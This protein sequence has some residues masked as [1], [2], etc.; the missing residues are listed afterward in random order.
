M[1]DH[2]HD[3]DVE[4][5]LP[6]G[7]DQDFILPAVIR[8]IFP[9]DLLADELAELRAAAVRTIVRVPLI[10]GLFGGFQ[11]VFGGREVRLA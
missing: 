11:D 1:I 2:R 10:H 5:R 8:A 6:P 7:S 3:G 9:F 4:S